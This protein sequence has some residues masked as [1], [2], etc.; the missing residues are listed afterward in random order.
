MNMSGVKTLL[1]WNYSLVSMSLLMYE[2]VV[3]AEMQAQVS[4][5]HE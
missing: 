1:A 4:R 2:S 3:G 5:V